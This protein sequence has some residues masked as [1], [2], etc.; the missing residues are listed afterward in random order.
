M[1]R[2]ILIVIAIA[3]CGCEPHAEQKTFSA[4]PPELNDCKVYSIYDG[5]QFYTVFRCPNS[6]TTTSQM[7][8]KT[9]TSVVV[10]DGKEYVEKGK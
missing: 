3:L 4:M 10:I 9:R 8:G 2:L 5:A 1:K 6:T 7:Q